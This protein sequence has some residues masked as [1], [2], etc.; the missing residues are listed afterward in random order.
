MARA[1]ALLALLVVPGWQTRASAADK[2]NVLMIAVDDLNHWIGHLGRNN[3]TKTPNLDALAARGVTFTR[4]NCAAPVCNP[5]RTALMS[6]MRPSTSGVYNNNQDFRPHVPRE[7]TLNATFKK[8]GY[9]LY[10]CGKIYHGSYDRKD[11]WDDYLK[12]SGDPKPKPGQNDGVG[13]IKF[14]PL[15]CKDEDLEDW[16]IADYAIQRLGEKHDK[17][18]FISCGFHKPHMPWNVPQKYYDKFPLESINLPPY[19]KDDLKDVP[20]AGVQMAKPNGDHKAMLDSGRW[21]EAVQAYLATINYLDMNVG[22]VIE[23]LDKSAYKNNTIVVL[24]GDHGWH[25]GEKDHWRKF[26][27]WEE[28][29]RM[30]YIW[31]VPGMTKAGGVCKSP[32]DLMSIY[33]TLCELASIEKPAHVE[34]LSIKPLLANPAA[35][36]KHFALTTHGYKNHGV[37]SDRWRYIRYE[38]GSEELYDHSKDEFEWTNL[39][40]DSSLAKVKAEL[41]KALPSKDAEG[42]SAKA[43]QADA[44]R[45][46]KKQARKAAKAK[47]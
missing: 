46:E 36:W 9:D 6:G 4:A 33:P 34:G 10:G 26:A 42:V 1:L 20:S 27:L 29:T 12:P 31:V 16:K 47:N 39:A 21:K 35:E 43:P 41:Q 30:P 5:S 45:Q 17:P 40:D 19:Q 24:W 15:D 14:A 3:Q 25:L 32:V 11:E 18:F 38:D 2:P 7:S 28:A 44:A 22:R 23:A 37:R 13:G 8:A